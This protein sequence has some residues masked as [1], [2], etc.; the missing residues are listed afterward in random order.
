MLFR[1]RFPGQYYDVETGM[2]YN[3][4]RYYDPGIGRYIS[5]DPIGQAGGVNRYSYVGNS[6]TN[7]IDPWGLDVLN[8]GNKPIQPHVQKAPDSFNY[9]LGDDKENRKNQEKDDC[10][11]LLQ[12]SLTPGIWKFFIGRVTFLGHFAAINPLRALCTGETAKSIPNK[13]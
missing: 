12:D 5:G 13:A 10:Q 4:F 7:L 8:P 2:H 3:R 11:T 1:S 6:P 9:Y